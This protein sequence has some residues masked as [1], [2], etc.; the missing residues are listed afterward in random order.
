MVII[1]VS[2]LVCAGHLLRVVLVNLLLVVLQLIVARDLV[3]PWL[4]HSWLETSH[5]LVVGWR[6][7]WVERLLV[8]VVLL[9]AV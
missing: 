9:V 7:L 4:L 5:S 2:A 6:L 8:C 1:V 3:E